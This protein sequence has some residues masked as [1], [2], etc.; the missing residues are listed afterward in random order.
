M[1]KSAVTVAAANG[2]YNHYKRIQMFPQRVN[3]R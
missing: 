3:D 2:V 1:G